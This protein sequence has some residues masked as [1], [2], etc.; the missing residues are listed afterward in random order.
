M[1]YITNIVLSWVTGVAN[2]DLPLRVTVLWVIMA[3]RNLPYHT[4]QGT[5][6]IYSA[7]VTS[8]LGQE[9]E[10]SLVKCG[11]L[12]LAGKMVT[13]TVLTALPPARARIDVRQYKVA[14]FPGLSEPGLWDFLN[15][16]NQAGQK[17]PAT[18]EAHHRDGCQRVCNLSINHI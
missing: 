2:S 12:L 5:M 16:V 17:N 8:S 11:E 7:T 13:Q 9:I 18:A 3:N 6:G 4:L 1:V 10:L 15:R 14:A